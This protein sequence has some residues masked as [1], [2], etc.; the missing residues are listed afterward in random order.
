MAEAIPPHLS[1]IVHSIMTQKESKVIV[2]I[3]LDSFFKVQQYVVA[4]HHVVSI[5]RYRSSRAVDFG[6]DVEAPK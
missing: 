6:K 1:L 2:M 3:A 4:A 5:W